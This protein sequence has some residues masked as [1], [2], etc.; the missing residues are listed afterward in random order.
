LSSFLVQ[1][2]YHN[3]FNHSLQCPAIKLNVLSYQTLA[4]PPDRAILPH[5]DISEFFAAVQQLS[6]L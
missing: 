5:W 6:H 4:P 2:D 3:Q 1:I